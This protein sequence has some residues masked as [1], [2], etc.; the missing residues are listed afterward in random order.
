V[1]PTPNAR[2]PR[3]AIVDDE[4][5][6]AT[7][8]EMALEDRGYDVVTTSS[9][10]EAMDLLISSEPDI[11]C[12]DLVMP[13]QTGIAVYAEILRHPDLEGCPVLI[14]SGL[15]V[16]ADL[17]GIL[18]RAGNLPEPAGFLEKPIDLDELSSAIER[19]LGR[20]AGGVA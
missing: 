3:V 8:L 19:L 16:G 6:I 4:E 18:E 11:I 15:A 1:S 17:K 12:L 7:Y 14:M 9:A 20:Q 2:P 10:K 5:D 13:R